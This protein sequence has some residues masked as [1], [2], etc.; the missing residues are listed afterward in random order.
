MV[1]EDY[2]IITVYKQTPAGISKVSEV[3]SHPSGAQAS[4]T[5]WIPHCLS[6]CVFLTLNR[7]IPSRNRAYDT[8]SEDTEPSLTPPLRV[9]ETTLTAQASPE[10]H[11]CLS[12][13]GRCR[14]SHYQRQTHYMVT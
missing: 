3:V 5:P 7:S 10:P 9:L 1:K 13:S 4:F 12:S 11:T 8:G 14:L 6:Q 2:T